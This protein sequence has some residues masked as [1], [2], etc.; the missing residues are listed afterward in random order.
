MISG[1]QGSLRMA[2]RM[3]DIENS[4]VFNFIHTDPIMVMQNYTARVAPKYH[5]QKAFGGR[6]PEKVWNDIEDQL[7]L[8]GYSEKFAN[9]S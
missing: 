7:R 1:I 5:F 4:K 2:H 6:T 8:D 9:M 3:I